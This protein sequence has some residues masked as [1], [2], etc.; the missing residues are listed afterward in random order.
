[1]II[2]VQVSCARRRSVPRRCSR[3]ND[4]V[5]VWRQAD[6]HTRQRSGIFSVWLQRFGSHNFLGLVYCCF[7]CFS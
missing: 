3:M 6:T 4:D 5:A 1:V 2:T 7:L